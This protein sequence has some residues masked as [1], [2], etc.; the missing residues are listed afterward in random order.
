MS[1]IRA[2]LQ[3]RTDG[4]LS[5]IRL[6]D[7]ARAGLR[8]GEVVL[9]DWHVTGLCCADAG[10]FSVRAIPRARVPRTMRRVADE[11]YV[12]PTAWAHLAEHDVEVRCR[13]YWRIRRFTTDLPPDAG[14]RACFGR[15]HPK[16]RT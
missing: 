5:V 12:H 13:T 14:L 3:R 2:L 4:A 8:P 11:V 6:A 1:N 9:V 15:L 7:S 16:E 10:E